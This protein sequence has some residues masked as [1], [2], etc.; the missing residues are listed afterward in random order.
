MPSHHPPLRQRAAA[1][2][3][4]TPR[5]LE[6]VRLVAGGLSNADIA[7]ELVVG[8]RAPR[9]GRNR[10]LV[11]HDR[12]WLLACRRAGLVEHSDYRRFALIEPP[13]LLTGRHTKILGS[14]DQIFADGSSIDRLRDEERCNLPN[15]GLRGRY[16]LRHGA[17]SVNHSVSLSHGAI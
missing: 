12:L 14:L 2:D 13:E 8:A 7:S 9:S 6:V 4:L 11:H 5:E 17:N 10:S 1:P 15:Q 3:E 16:D